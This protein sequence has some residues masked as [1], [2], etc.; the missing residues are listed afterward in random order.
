M[1]YHFYK[2]IK[3][4]LFFMVYIKSF[5]GDLILFPNSLE[6]AQIFHQI[7]KFIVA[8]RNKG[9]RTTEFFDAETI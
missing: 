9:E 6:E 7:F 8:T 1:H 5:N 3:F 2:D 4:Y